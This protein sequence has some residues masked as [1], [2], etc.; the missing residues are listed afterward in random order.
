MPKQSAGIL[1]WQRGSTEIEVLLVHPGGP[2]FARKDAGVWSI[3]K[4]EYVES[5]DL[6]EVAKR[7]FAEEVGCPAPSGTYLTL[8][9]IAQRGGK[10]V[11]AFAVEGTCAPI[12]GASNTFTMEWPP[13]SG[14][15]QEFPEVDQAEWFPIS[16]AREKLNGAQVA[17]LEELTMRIVTSSS[18]V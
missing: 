5:E 1:L 11:H 12:A 7:E 10:I 13:R 15:Q 8:A 9:P 4:G 2:F 18:M 17:L 16:I 6:L 14:R 3:P